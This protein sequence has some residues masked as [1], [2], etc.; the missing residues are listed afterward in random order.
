MAGTFERERKKK[1]MEGG[2]Q[3]VRQ[4]KLENYFSGSTKRW[5]TSGNYSLKYN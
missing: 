2:E 3:K 5:Q 1:E 4:F